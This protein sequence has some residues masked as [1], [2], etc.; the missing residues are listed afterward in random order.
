MMRC[1]YDYGFSLEGRR[2]EA[3]SELTVKTETRLVRLKQPFKGPITNW[4][5]E[6][7]Q[8]LR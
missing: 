2:A 5:A 8:E 7:R 6:P 4:R 1:K 3:G